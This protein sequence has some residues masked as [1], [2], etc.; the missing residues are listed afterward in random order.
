[1]QDLT[2]TYVAGEQ[3]TQLQRSGAR[4][5][6][7][8]TDQEP[9]TSRFRFHTTPIKDVIQLDETELQHTWCR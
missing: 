7:S 4:N 8:G 2:S 6:D 9:A 1:L 5:F 3:P